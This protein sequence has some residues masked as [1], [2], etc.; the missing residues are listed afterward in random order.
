MGT[1]TN[2]VI[3][4]IATR[5]HRLCHSLHRSVILFS[6]SQK[7]FTGK[8][9]FMA[10][11]LSLLLLGACNNSQTPQPFTDSAGVGTIHI[12]VDESFKPAIEQQIKLYEDTYPKAHIIAH[13]KPEVECF[14]DLQSDSTRMVIVA[15]NLTSQ[16]RDYYN[17][18]LNFPV[19]DGTT[20]Y[21]AVAVIINNEAKDSVYAI[22]KLKDILS[23]KLNVPAIMDGKNATSTVRYLQDTLLKGQPFGAN[24]VGAGSSKEVVAAI[25][26]DK[27]AIGFVGL[28]W[29]GNP[30]EPEQQ[31]YF[32]HIRYALVECLICDEKGV[33]AKPS[34]ATITY[35][36]YP[37]ARPL[38]Y[39]VK[40]NAARLGTSFKN[41][42]NSE[43]GQLIFRRAFMA[44]AKMDFRI[45]GSNIKDG[46]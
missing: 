32:Q 2:V 3:G 34:Q 9:G 5:M 43:R 18:K 40:E 31:Q 12:S 36:Q 6:N 26:K 35:L 42:M 39:I 22:Q 10:M 14:K 8:A 19:Q 11:C 25:M 20:A 1:Y 16:E 44:P 45:R 46:N 27:N 38:H 7:A 15:R 28:S 30:T 29:V 41:F 24:V 17:N 21:D 37:L 4:C 33:Y 23:G 13:Y